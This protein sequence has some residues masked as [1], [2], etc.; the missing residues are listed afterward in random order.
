MQGLSRVLRAKAEEM[1]FKEQP[2]RGQMNVSSY[3]FSHLC[4]LTTLPSSSIQSH[5]RDAAHKL[6]TQLSF[7]AL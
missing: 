2:L 6:E 5:T 4:F 1:G 3:H 7:T